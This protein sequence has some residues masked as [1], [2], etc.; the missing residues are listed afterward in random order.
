[1]FAVSALGCAMAGCD[2]ATLR[3]GALD[4]NDAAGP[5]PEAAALLPKPS[6]ACPPIN[7]MQYPSLRGTTCTPGVCGQALDA[8]RAWQTPDQLAAALA[9]PWRFCAGSFGPH[10]A[11]G[12][13]FDPGCALFLLRQDDAGAFVAG[14]EAAYQGTFDVVTLG[15]AVDGIVLHLETGDVHAS[16]TASSCLARARIEATDAAAVELASLLD[17]GSIPAQ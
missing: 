3:L 4:G 8:P 2:G 5:A 14:T 10:D 15:G 12:V 1:M 6:L 9:G 17:A 16:V 13:E 7:E 11:V